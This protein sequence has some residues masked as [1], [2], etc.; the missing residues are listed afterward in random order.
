MLL[1]AKMITGAPACPPIFRYLNCLLNPLWH[2][3][4]TYEYLPTHCV[5]IVPAL[6]V[7]IFCGHSINVSI[8]IDLPVAPQPP[9]ISL[10]TLPDFV[11][12]WYPFIRSPSPDYTPFSRRSSIFLQLYN[13]VEISSLFSAHKLYS[14]ASPHTHLFIFFPAFSSLSFFFAFFLYPFNFFSFYKYG[15]VLFH[16]YCRHS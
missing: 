1:A 13:K 4:P 10:D 6:I 11:Y 7:R 15:Y 9:T 16:Q 12:S 5:V 14:A 2:P 3:R 8:C